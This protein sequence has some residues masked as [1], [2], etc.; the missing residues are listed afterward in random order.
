MGHDKSIHKSHYRQPIPELEIPRIANLLQLATNINN[1]HETSVHNEA[2]T[3]S[4]IISANTAEEQAR[5]PSD[6]DDTNKNGSTSK[7]KK[8]RKRRS[9][10]PFGTTK[11]RLWTIEEQ[12][13]L[14]TRFKK[15]VQ[16]SRL[17]SGID[18]TDCIQ[19]D[20]RLSRRSVPQIRSWLHNIIRGK[21]KKPLQ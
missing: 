9:T 8:Q 16:N 7:N 18:I 19:R 10:S 5:L 11:R 15:E 1:E 2:S 6:S 17:P 20:P 21:V 3:S 14:L 13:A 4:N 12:T